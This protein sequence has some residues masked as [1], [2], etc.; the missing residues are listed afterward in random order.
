MA[1]RELRKDQYVICFEKKD[2]DEI[3]DNPTGVTPITDAQKRNVFKQK[4][5][6][7]NSDGALCYL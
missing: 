2:Y 7:L 4:K 1:F 6:S 3:V 5:Y